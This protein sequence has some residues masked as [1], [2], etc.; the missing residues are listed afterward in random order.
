MSDRFHP[1][2]A[3]PQQLRL[4][5]AR[6]HARP[7]EPGVC[8]LEDYTCLTGESFVMRSLRAQLRRAAPHFRIALII[9]ETGTL[10]ETV[11]LALHRL[12][13]ESDATFVVHTPASLLSALQEISARP[14]LLSFPDASTA[15]AARS[16]FFLPDVGDLSHGEQIC[17]LQSLKRVASLRTG[18]ERP[19]LIFATGRDLR[20]L[21]G[22]GHFDRSLYRMISAVEVLL[23]PLRSRPEDIPLIT[24]G[25]LSR[26][27][28]S[29]AFDGR[30]LSSLQCHDWPG[31]IRELERVVEVA[32]QRAG[33][34]ADGTHLDGS[35][36]VIEAI[37]LP[38]LGEFTRANQQTRIESRID[39]LDD[40]IQNHVL[41]VLLRCSGNKVRAAERL[42]ISRSTLYR[43]LDASS[44]SAALDR[45]A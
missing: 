39:R 12:N 42:G 30:A 7:E 24:C 16:T 2:T 5:H 36:G 43:M 37:H 17:L 33:T 4:Q 13:A 32:R 27:A 25:L 14:G 45:I 9:G 38:P 18:A 40:V 8:A 23:P 21:S 31:N 35:D 19:R 26:S 10:K 11:A 6:S 3:P 29:G 44:S 41:D 22:A 15:P 28:S 34:A 20:S 1:S